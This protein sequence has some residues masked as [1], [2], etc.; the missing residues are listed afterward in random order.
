MEPS[1]TPNSEYVEA[2]LNYAAPTEEKLFNYMY[3]PPPGMP[4]TNRRSDPRTVLIRNGRTCR[5]ELSLD[6]QGFTL[7]RFPSAVHN[8]CADAE[9]R[10]VYYPEVERLLKNATGG[11]KILIF[12]YTWRSEA[13]EKRN[14]SIKD[15]VRAV[16][17]DYTVTSGPQRV[18]E[19]LP[20]TEA[21]ER[22]RRRFAEV[23]VWRPINGP[24]L[25]APLAVCDALSIEQPDL[26]ETEQRYPNRH[27]EI[28]VLRFNPAHR[29]FYFPRMQS[30]E[31]LL[32]KGYDSMQDG[33]AR[34]T[35]HTSFTDPASP[36]GAPPR[37]SIELRALVFFG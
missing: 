18:R 15:P 13:A 35:A 29:W 34:F 25:T 4:Q 3:P 14:P 36:A 32:I 26:A 30:D 5:A 31:A 8:F 10:G 9:V 37:A 17:V 33:R 19:L 12:D 28:Y 20:P 2:S 1:V 22:L 16:H 6:K 23:N 21:E 11:V 27:G 24:V 7:V